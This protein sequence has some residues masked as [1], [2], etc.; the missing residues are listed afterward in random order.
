M[1]NYLE[2]VFI[3]GATG[4]VGSYIAVRLLQEGWQVYALRRK[5]SGLLP[6]HLPGLTWIQ[7][8]IS[9][10]AL[11]G[12]WIPQ[13]SMVVH[14]AGLVSFRLSHYRQL[15]KVNEEGT[16]N[17]VN[18]AL[19]HPHLKV[20]CF[21]SSV[22]ALGGKGQIIDE[23]A[24]WDEH[25]HYSY[26]ALSK[27]LAERQVWRG[28]AEGLPAVIVNPSVVL[29][30]PSKGS[31][32]AQLFKLALQSPRYPSGWINLVDA[33]DVAEAVVLLL[34]HRITSERFILSAG[35][36]TYAEFFA[37]IC[38]VLGKPFHKKPLA[39]GWIKWLG[40]I[41]NW[42][43]ADFNRQVA[44]MAIQKVHYDGNKITRTV[45]LQYTPLTESIRKVA[46]SFFNV[47]HQLHGKK[48]QKE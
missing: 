14:A 40:T 48:E 4:L 21:I 35:A 2:K 11:L 22:A 41:G 23:N 46:L 9:D 5:G 47:S 19:D 39:D 42:I 6:E 15:L 36:L 33:A 43:D 20:F 32:L 10:I 38:Q 18:V 1:A 44:E 13:V 27:H 34:K 8:D 25:S 7:G 30:T 17:L 28:I 45:N 12:E 3:T 24:K 16:A 37:H 31:S 29:G 26:Y